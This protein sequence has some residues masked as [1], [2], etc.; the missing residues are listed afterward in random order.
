MPSTDEGVR[1]NPGGEEGMLMIP[2]AL[3][4]SGRNS[5]RPIIDTAILI[6]EGSPLLHKRSSTLSPISYAISNSTEQKKRRKTYPVC[7][8]LT[9]RSRVSSNLS[10]MR[11]Q[12]YLFMTRK[13]I[14]GKIPLCIYLKCGSIMSHNDK[15]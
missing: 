8:A 7:F 3:Y 2:R 15:K 9:E 11:Q 14:R 4:F 12:D 1:N 10:S 6:C 13:R 5:Q